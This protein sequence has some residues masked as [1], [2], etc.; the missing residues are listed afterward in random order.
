MEINILLQQKLS[1][2][3]QK[4]YDYTTDLASSNPMIYSNSN[5]DYLIFDKLEISKR[6]G[7]SMLCVAE[8]RV[9]SL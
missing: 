8:I 3:E 2:N 9:L 1:K 7:N 6:H 5:I 4:F